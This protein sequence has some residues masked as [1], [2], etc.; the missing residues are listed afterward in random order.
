MPKDMGYYEGSSVAHRTGM[1][2]VLNQTYSTS[3]AI[4]QGATELE[5]MSTDLSQSGFVK[6]MHDLKNSII[7]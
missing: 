2:Q 3:E 6:Y 5:S 4:K 1:N 7:N